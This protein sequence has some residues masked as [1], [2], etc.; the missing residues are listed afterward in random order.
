MIPGRDH[1]LHRGR[2]VALSASS[3]HIVDIGGRDF[4]PNGRQLYEEGLN[5]AILPFVKRGEFNSLPLDVVRVNV[6]G[7]VEVEGDIDSF[8]A[9]N[10]PGER[11][12]VEMMID[13]FDLAALDDISEYVI[14]ASQVGLFSEIR[15][16]RSGTFR[17]SMQIDGYEHELVILA[18][19]TIDEN[20]MSVDFDGIN[21]SIACT[22]ACAS[23]AVC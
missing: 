3:T 19:V 10:E 13:A 22:E 12:L 9:C 2:I 7:P 17:N 14:H 23:F 1:D 6:R 16:L 20:G 5:S 8:A 11:R 15:A 4:G 18:T 21:A